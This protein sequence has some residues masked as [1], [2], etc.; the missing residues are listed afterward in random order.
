[1]LVPL[2]LRLSGVTLF[3]GSH[4][5]LFLKRFGDTVNGILVSKRMG[6]WYVLSK[7][8][9]TAYTLEE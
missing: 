8:F 2:L 7:S 5:G 4:T 3:G 1:V 9:L 6:V